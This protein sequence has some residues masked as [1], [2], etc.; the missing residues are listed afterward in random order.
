MKPIA[1]AFT[2]AFLFLAMMIVIPARVSAQQAPPHCVN[3]LLCLFNQEAMASDFRGIHKYSEDLI[4]LIVSNPAND[5]STRQLANRFADRLANA[6][7]AAR[8]GNGK[9]VPEVAVAKAFNDLMYEIGAP[10]SMRATVASVHGFRDHAASIKVFPALLSADRN[11]SNCNPGEAVFLLS[12]LLSDSGVLLEGN[13]DGAVVLMRS[14]SQ[15]NQD[16]SGASSATLESMDSSA[17]EKLF[18][19]T[20]H[21]DTDTSRALL[22]KVAKTLAF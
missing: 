17:A 18:W 4:G 21:H 9:V 8:T 15:H 1:E 11:G 7:Q 6:E 5:D 3:V 14:D 2:T 20:Y 12:L 22:E 16:R 19:Y 13:I 10:P